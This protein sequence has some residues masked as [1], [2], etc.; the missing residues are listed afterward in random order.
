[1]PKVPTYYN[2]YTEFHQPTQ[3]RHIGVY[4]ALDRAMLRR[5]ASGSD[6]R[7]AFAAEA[8]AL[9]RLARNC[10]GYI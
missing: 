7:S 10:L 6:R 9:I 2:T 8:E 3:R 1:M 4:P 5:G